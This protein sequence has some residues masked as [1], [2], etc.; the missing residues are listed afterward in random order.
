MS[1]W[2]GQNFPSFRKSEHMKPTDLLHKFFIS[3]QRANTLAEHLANYIPVNSNVIDIGCGSGSIAARLKD[4]RPD[5]KITG[6]DPL[7]QSETKIE[8][9]HFDGESLPFDDHTFDCAILIDVIHHAEKPEKLL[10]EAARVSG[11]RVVIKDHLC[12]SKIDD[13]VLTFMDRVGNCRFGI[14]L[15][16]TYFSKKKWLD[17]FSSLE[18]RPKQ[19][20]E[21]LE[22]YSPALRPFFERSLHF[23]CF[24]ESGRAPDTPNNH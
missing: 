22:L 3:G 20:N 21:K 6:A 16:H 5:L 10:A 2:L 13:F 9:I 1:N 24:L 8:V 23:M 12:E 18:L 11:N 14:N 4:L 7:V 17:L 19:W 15:P